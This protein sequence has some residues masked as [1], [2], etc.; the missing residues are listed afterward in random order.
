MTTNLTAVLQQILQNTTN[1]KVL[2]QHMTAGRHLRFT[3]LR[4]P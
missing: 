2:R 3:E 4:Q 1:I